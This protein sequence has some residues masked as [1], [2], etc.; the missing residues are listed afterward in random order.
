MPATALF[1]ATT[2]TEDSDAVGCATGTR[3]TGLLKKKQRVDRSKYLMTINNSEDI[4]AERFGNEFRAMNEACWRDE[5][6]T[7]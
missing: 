6:C 2:T 4:D 7:C 1:G 3:Y 5:V